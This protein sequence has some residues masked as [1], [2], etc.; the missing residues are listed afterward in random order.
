MLLE[1][2][3]KENMVKTCEAEQRSKMLSTLLRLG[4]VTREVGSFMKKQLKQQ[5][6][7]RGPGGGTKVFKSG[8][9]R[10]SDKLSDCRADED[11]LRRERDSLRSELEEKLGN[12]NVYNRIMKKLKTKVNR[13]RLDIKNK[14]RNKIAQYVKEKEDEDMTELASLREELGEFGNLKIF[15]GITIQPEERKPPVTS[16]EAILSN[17]ELEIL[18]KNPK[19]AIRSVMSKER[20]MV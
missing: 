7:R 11:K 3:L 15:Q 10:M 17:D 9:Q 2:E 13:I 12:K 20:F 4:L 1:R 18:S 8:K 16:G 5:R 6:R 14:H 19:F